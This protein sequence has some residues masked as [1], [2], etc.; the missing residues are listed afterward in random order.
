MPQL[1]FIVIGFGALTVG[2]VFG[3]LARQSIARRQIGSIEE[4]ITTMMEVAKTEAKDM[5]FRAKD[6]SVKFLEEAKKEEK[7]RMFQL[8]RQA[9]RVLRKEEALDRKGDIFEK[10]KNDL[11][12]KVE[13]VKRIKTEV[14]KM[15]EEERKVLETIAKMSEQEAKN[16]LLQTV[17]KDYRDEIIKTIKKLE[18]EKVDTIEKKAFDIMALSIQRYARSNVADIMTSAV[19]IPNDELKGRIIG[20]EGRNIKAL[21]RATGVEIIVD[22]TPGVITISGF[23]PIRREIARIT[24]DKLIKDGRIQPAKIEEKVEEARKEIKQKIQEMGEAAVSEVGIIGFPA[25]II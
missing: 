7:E 13:E 8:T 18:Q 9:E 23:N 16:N 4:K 6:R 21:E 24:I 12:Y 2:S 10:E 17:E 14:A 11:V 15:H 22:E 19:S 1:I 25:Q 3:Y 5:I 20:R